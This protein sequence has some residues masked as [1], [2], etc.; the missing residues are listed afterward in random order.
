MTAALV[1]R[2]NIASLGARARASLLLLVRRYHVRGFPKRDGFCRAGIG[3]PREMTG[4]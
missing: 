1:D 2:G 3:G 4:L